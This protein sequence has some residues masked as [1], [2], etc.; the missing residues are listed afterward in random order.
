MMDWDIVI[1]SLVLVLIVQMG[2]IFR[3]N[4]WSG[5]MYE[6]CHTQISWIWRRPL[7][8]LEQKEG[9]HLMEAKNL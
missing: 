2:F 6:K 7:M 4:R 8:Q 3:E 9:S 1:F 5:R